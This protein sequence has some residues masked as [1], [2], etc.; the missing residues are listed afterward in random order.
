MRRRRGST[1]KRTNPC[2]SV[3]IDPAHTGSTR[4][5]R[6]FAVT[7][8]DDLHALREM[9]LDLVEQARSKLS[10][11]VFVYVYRMVAESDPP[12]PIARGQFVRSGMPK[13]LHPL[14]IPGFD[15]EVTGG[16]VTVDIQLPA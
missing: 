2:L 14:G 5:Y 12:L 6:V 7:E 8:T 1:T 9:I 15:V 10:D 16:T 11:I 13:W 4:R 3:E